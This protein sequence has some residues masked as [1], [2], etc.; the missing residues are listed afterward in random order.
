MLRGEAKGW[1]NWSEYA[2]EAS[3]PGLCFGQT[4]GSEYNEDPDPAY[5]LR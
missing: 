3:D 1:L 5:E 2:F 4:P